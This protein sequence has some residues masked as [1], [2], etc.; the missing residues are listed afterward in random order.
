MNKSGSLSARNRPRRAGE[1]GQRKRPATWNKHNK[2]QHKQQLAR[3]PWAR[4]SWA[5]STLRGATKGLLERKAIRICKCI[6]LSLSLSLSLPLSL[7]IYIYIYIYIYTLSFT[8]LRTETLRAFRSCPTNCQRVHAR[9][10]RSL[11]VTDVVSEACVNAVGH[12]DMTHMGISQSPVFIQHDDLDVQLSHL[13]FASTILLPSSF[14]STRSHHTN[15]Y[16][17]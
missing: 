16:S 4:A 9:P 5:T 15:L 8:A 12:L 11:K 2:P 17:Y 13:H 14:L 3:P 6:H 10:P 1:Q 7:S